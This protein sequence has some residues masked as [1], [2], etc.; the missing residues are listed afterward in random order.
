[1]AMGSLLISRVE[2]AAPP[3]LAAQQHT[4]LTVFSRVLF[5]GY[6]ERK[7]SLVCLLAEF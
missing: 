5:S 6:L 3:V 7:N 1:M 2:I 4:L